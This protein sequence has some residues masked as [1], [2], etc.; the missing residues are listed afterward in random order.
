[1]RLKHDKQ[2]LLNEE[3]KREKVSEGK[4]V[5]YFMSEMD[6]GKSEG[7]QC[8]VGEPDGLLD[9]SLQQLLHVHPKKGPRLLQHLNAPPHLRFM[10]VFNVIT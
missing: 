9:A 5:A 2:E 10:L 3:L 8:R 1:M 6:L 4:L 7:L